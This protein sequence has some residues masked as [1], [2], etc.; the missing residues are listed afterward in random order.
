MATFT[1][2][3]SKWYRGQGGDFSALLLRNDGK[4]CCIGFVGQQCGI[5]DKALLNRAVAFD[6]RDDRWPKWILEVNKS[7]STDIYEAY[8]VNDSATI[9]DAERERRLKAIFKRNGDRIRFV[10]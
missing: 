3:R 6:V 2:K 5:P 1:V 8:G 7:A 9:S 4:R 10:A